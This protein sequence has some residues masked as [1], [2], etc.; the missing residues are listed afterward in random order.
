MLARR[1]GRV[2]GKEASCRAAGFNFPRCAPCRLE[3][4]RYSDLDLR[5][6]SFLRHCGDVTRLQ[7]A[8]AGFDV[9]IDQKDVRFTPPEPPGEPLRAVGARESVGETVIGVHTP[10]QIT[11]K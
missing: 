8:R 6:K 1:R 4:P 9:P 10:G 11:V 2:K 7:P 5:W 3:G